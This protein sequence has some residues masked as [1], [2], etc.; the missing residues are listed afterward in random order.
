MENDPERNDIY[1]PRRT[2]PSRKKLKTPITRGLTLILAATFL[3]SIFCLS[4]TAEFVHNDKSQQVIPVQKMV[5]DEIQGY[6]PQLILEELNTN[7]T[8]TD[9]T[10][11]TPIIEEDF[12]PIL[13]IVTEPPRSYDKGIILC[14][15]DGIASL[16]KS[17]IQELRCLGNTEVVQIYHCLPN[18]LSKESRALLTHND[19]KVEF[20]DVCTEYLSSGVFDQEMAD[21]F[22]SYWIKALAVYHTNITE[23]LLIDADAIFM[24]DPATIR[25]TSRYQETGTLFF[26]D[27]VLEKPHYLNTPTKVDEHATNSVMQPYLQLWAQRFDYG[28]FNITSPT[29]S[30]HLQNSFSFHGRSCH[31]QDSSLVAINKQ[32]ASKPLEILWF[33][34]TE[35]R[36]RFKFSWGDKEAFWLS[37][38]FAQQ[39]YSFSPW[40]VSAIE[41]TT[42]QDFERHPQ[43]LCG[44]MAHWFP[45]ETEKPELFYLNGRALI[46]PYPLGIEQT[47]KDRFSNMFNLN[48]RYISPRSK[49]RSVL[50]VPEDGK[51][52]PECLAGFG[53]TLL[54]EIFQKRIW[55]RRMHFFG[56]KS[57]LMEPLEICETKVFSKQL[58]L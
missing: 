25:T 4:F 56:L 24:Q 38:E 54:P 35:E 12:E 58:N 15:H 16:G 33:L 30:D 48:P 20:V 21:S 8:T 26:Y 19:S 23:L 14:L 7:N 55:R 49:R 22:R 43:T 34:M 46:E 36:F 42:N 37:W 13:P 6:G 51:K 47:V 10:S 44:S 57:G 52:F 2:L 31:E 53:S 9:A 41:S 18:E 5:R 40:G 17:L 27:R 28:R 1:T 32:N 3:M 29:L 50:Y 45:E 39:K 11:S